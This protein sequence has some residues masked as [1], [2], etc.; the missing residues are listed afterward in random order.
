MNSQPPPFYALRAKRLDLLA[1]L[2]LALLIMALQYAS[3]AYSKDFADDEDEPAHVV[4]SL[5]V[6][7]YIAHGVPQNPLQF[8]TNYYAHYPKVAIGHWPPGFHLTEALWMLLFGR[9]RVAL[10]S[11]VAAV[12][13]S[14]AASVFLWLRQFGGI[15]A[16]VVVSAVLATR[17]VVEIATYSVE[18]DILLA[19]LVFWSVAVYGMYLQHRQRRYLLAFVCLALCA[20]GVHGRGVVLA[21]VPPFAELLCGSCKHKGRWLSILVLL[22]VMAL[23]LPRLMA[24]AEPSTVA[25]V[26]EH[27]WKTAYQM[28]SLIGWPIAI[29]AALGA[30]AVLRFRVASPASIAMLSLLL[31]QWLFGSLVNVS[32]E[33]RY[34]LVVL[35]ILAILYAMAWRYLPTFLPARPL[36]ARTSQTGLV[37]IACLVLIPGILTPQKKRD[38]LCHQALATGSLLAS[39]NHIDLVAGGAI[40]EGAFIAEMALKDP[41]FHHTV[42]RASKVLASSSWS[43]KHYQTRFPDA[44][45]VADYLDRTHVSI[46]LIEPVATTQH[47]RQLREALASR[48]RTWQFVPDVF[49]PQ[50]FQVFRRRET[51]SPSQERP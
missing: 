45:G 23:S 51:T 36:L 38:L 43:G 16:A 29:P 7:D 18:T 5:M 21:F 30:V 14:L 11:L 28:C 34:T 37:L 24:Q 9:S 31:A 2:G 42:L 20:C 40:H 15:G 13:A 22:S 3:G 25:S 27:A 10:I 46:V 26:F 33:N 39:P 41:H 6:R 1:I 12:S 49:P 35:P 19:L 48:P 44:Q 8:A 17:P 4:S 32:L 50:I 47:V